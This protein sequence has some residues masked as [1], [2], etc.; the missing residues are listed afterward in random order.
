MNHQE[1]RAR[2]QKEV[3]S[4]REDFEADME[5]RIGDM[6]SKVEKDFAEQF[7]KD[8]FLHQC[9]K[10]INGWMARWAEELSRIYGREVT[11]D[12]IKQH[13]ENVGV[14]IDIDEGGGFTSLF[15][16]ID[17]HWSDADDVDPG[18]PHQ[19]LV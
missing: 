16:L 1:Q 6:V 9:R 14:G 7:V 5:R 3:Q 8:K 11:V 18:G 15:S 19:S 13:L 4:V 12:E 10:A 2:Y 17:H